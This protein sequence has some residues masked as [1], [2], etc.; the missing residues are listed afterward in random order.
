VNR[1]LRI[2]LRW[3]LLAGLVA[4]CLLTARSDSRMVVPDGLHFMPPHPES[5][6]E[7]ITEV[8]AMSELDKIERGID[9]PEYIPN[10]PSGDFN[11]LV[12][13]VDFPDQ[14]ATMTDPVGLQML[15]DLFFDDN[16]SVADYYD[17]IS[18][19]SLKLRMVD[20]H[21]P[22]E[23][24]WQ[25]TPEYYDFYVNYDDYGWGEYPHNLQGIVDHIISNMDDDIDF[26]QYD[27]DGDSFVDGVV[28]V[29]AGAAAELTLDSKDI[30]SA[31]WD[32]SSGNG[33]G[34]I[35]VD[36][37]FVDNFSFGPEYLVDSGDITIG[38]FAHELGHMLFGLPDLYDLGQSS[39]GVGNWS[40]MSYGAWNG[41][42]LICPEWL[43][44]MTNG[45]SPAWPDAWSRIRM[46]FESPQVIT[47]NITGF[48]FFP[49]ESN[50][51]NVVKLWTPN[52][53]DQEYFLVEYRQKMGYDEYLPGEDLLIWH[54]DETKWN[55]WEL[56]LTECVASPCCECE[57]NHPLLALM[58]ADS[59]L[60]LEK[61][62]N[63]G[64]PS[65]PFKPLVKTSFKFG[66]NPE[67]GSYYASPCDEDSCIAVDNIASVDGPIRAD[68]KVICTSQGACVD[69]LTDRLLGW[70]EAGE[71]TV[72]EASIQN[73]GNA[74]DFLTLSHESGWDV[75]F[76][77]LHSDELIPAGLQVP[78]G[79]SWEVGIKV[80][81]PTDALWGS[82]DTLSLTVTSAN[83][84]DISAT[85]SLT[86]NVP[87]CTL[88]VDDDRD[89]PN[90]RGAYS[91]SLTG[92]GFDFDVWDTQVMGSPDEATLA[93]YKAVLWF[94]GTPNRDTLTPHDEAGLM[95]YLDG[96][97]SFFLSSQEFL[98]DTLRD[99]FGR[100]YLGVG[101][102][103]DNAGT[104]S[105]TGVPGNPLSDE[106]GTYTM[107]AATLNSDR[108]NPFST[109]LVSTDLELSAFKDDTGKT[110]AITHDTGTWRSV[111]LGWPLENLYQAD[112]KELLAST[113]D[114]MGVPPRPLASFE[115]SVDTVCEGETITFN[116]T[117]SNASVFL[118][119]FGDG[120]IST[121]TDALHV[122]TDSLIATVVLTGT[123]SCGY[124]TAASTITV[125][126]SP[127]VEF[128]PSTDTI[129]VNQPVTFSLLDPEIDTLLFYL[130]DFDDGTALSRETTPT[131]IFSESGWYTVTLATSDEHCTGITSMMINVK[132]LIYLPLMLKK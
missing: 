99:Y 91:D 112:G 107:S 73:C 9:V 118:W 3:L 119:S 129:Y 4:A 87:Y 97:G 17:D 120:A 90:V 132:Q 78:A 52:L 93:T 117:S 25:R 15:D 123:N 26:S 38:V 82:A 46:G 55:R 95:S 13:L 22:S 7:S 109:E 65:D 74:S 96:G 8:F 10:P 56:N 48:E 85:A 44:C 88:L 14:Q 98:A 79:G 20:E 30:W 42:G 114:W 23:I 53:D 66:T 5:S 27:N 40:L 47:Q 34:P 75:Q 77:D 49:V 28:F 115:L 110:N 71:T 36:G 127:Q 32:M 108:M 37:V 58:Q 6:E 54:V 124:D 84:E 130:W 101:T 131:H 59:V 104:T 51:G 92:A 43:P 106:L 89:A 39:Y 63:K 116:N 86:T 83:D 122:Y 69:I 35:P 18:F 33:P 16:E 11:L 19:G 50:S 126:D 128:T 68:L 2:S 113:L 105:V 45:D 61:K 62:E 94:T 60:D 57:D 24:G 72:Y 102:F 121:Q 29:H 64:D 76:V 80:T 12:V 31:T 70:G 100:N 1:S 81:S 41:E 67:S 111:F 125:Y 21:K 103:V